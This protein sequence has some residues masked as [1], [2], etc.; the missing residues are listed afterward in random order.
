MDDDW[1]PARCDIASPTIAS[2]DS[3]LKFNR[4][5][6][7]PEVMCLGVDIRNSSRSDTT[8]SGPGNAADQ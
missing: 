4:N 6:S 8:H 7:L 2:T 3:V 1:L 5:G